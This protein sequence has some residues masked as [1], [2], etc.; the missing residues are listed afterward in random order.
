LQTPGTSW[1][2]TELSTNGA[3]GDIPLAPK[4]P[5]LGRAG[6]KAKK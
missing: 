5:P 6:L 1:Q 4:H 3:A 2:D